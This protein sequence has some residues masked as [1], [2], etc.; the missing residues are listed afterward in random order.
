MRLPKVIAG[1]AD[2]VAGLPGEWSASE[3]IVLH[4]VAGP[5]CR[6]YPLPGHGYPRT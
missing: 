1:A 3:P 5:P 2:D 4:G 6:E